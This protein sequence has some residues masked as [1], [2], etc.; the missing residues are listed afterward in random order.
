MAA[1]HRPR[2][3][4]VVDAIDATLRARRRKR[5]LAGQTPPWWQNNHGSE[6][7][8][9]G[10][11][12]LTG[13]HCGQ[14]FAIEIKAPGGRPTPRQRIELRWLQRAGSLA[15]VADDA[16]RVRELLD[17]IEAQAGAVPAGLRSI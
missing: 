12:D 16:E 3:D 11:P 4:A 7:G 6:F 15:I 13:A 17:S 14:H 10:I 8:R 2:E 1:K 5:I 9:A